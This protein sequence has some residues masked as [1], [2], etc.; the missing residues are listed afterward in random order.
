VQV[1]KL[2][3]D[4]KDYEAHELSMR[5]LLP[6]MRSEIEGD[7]ACEIAKQSIHF[8]GS[9]IGDD[10]LDTGWRVYQKLVKASN[11]ANGISNGEADD[12]EKK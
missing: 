2:K 1:L 10:I 5:V 7:L 12:E 6:L 9:P 11:Q 4:G 8:G 3:I